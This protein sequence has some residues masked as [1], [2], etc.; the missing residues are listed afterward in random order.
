[1]GVRGPGAHL[2][3][4]DTVFSC[5]I[6]ERYGGGLWTATG[7]KVDIHLHET[8]FFNNTAVAVA[9]ARSL[10]SYFV[11]DDTGVHKNAAGG[12]WFSSGMS[13]VTTHPTTAAATLQ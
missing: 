5:N 4:N 10:L 3:I 8:R 1:M 12:G 2:H 6:A 7:I 13:G 9:S 11:I